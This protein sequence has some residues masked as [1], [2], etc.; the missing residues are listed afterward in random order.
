MAH[1]PENNSTVTAHSSSGN[2]ALIAQAGFLLVGMLN[3]LLGPVLP[4]L[5]A[6]WRLDDAQ[7][8]RL[9]AA[10]FTGALLSSS[11]SGIFSRRLGAR[12]VLT[13]GYGLLAVS[14]FCLGLTDWL[15]GFVS[16]VCL[17]IGL[18]LTIPATNLLIAE[19]NSERSAAALNLT[20]LIWSIGAI[21]CPPFIS[22]LAREGALAKPLLVIAGLSAITAMSLA[23]SSA[24][25]TS[26]QTEQPGKL[27]AALLRSLFQRELLLIGLL[28]FLYVG[29]E[30]ALGGWLA[31]FVQRLDTSPGSAWAL[32]SALFWAGLLAGRAMAPFALRRISDARLILFSIFAA[33]SGMT[34]ILLSSDLKAISTG[35]VLA[36]LGMAAIFPTTFAIFTQR[37]GALAS[38]LSGVVFVSASLGAASFPW[39]VGLIS[40]LAGGLRAGLGMLVFNGAVMILLHLAIHSLKT[41]NSNPPG[42][43]KRSLS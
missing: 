35:T 7:A 43:A 8:G 19:L 2:I 15:A 40:S 9:F 33:V 34:I 26:N 14:V 10:Q 30:T 37:F 21:I 42:A 1:L 36:G 38:E 4:L 22:L 39:L 25:N 24:P 28:I 12:F 18:G 41:V 31:S 17:G 5:S 20:N 13:L 23:S 16:I 6:R 11:V 3:T 29:I 27:N 32:I